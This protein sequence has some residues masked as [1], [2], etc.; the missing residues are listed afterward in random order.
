MYQPYDI[1]NNLQTKRMMLASFAEK[2]HALKVGLG[3]ARDTTL[4]VRGRSQAFGRFL[5]GGGAGD[6]IVWVV[7]VAPFG[8]NVK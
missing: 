1:R 5:Q 8:V 2:H 4:T 7:N 3:E 6:Y